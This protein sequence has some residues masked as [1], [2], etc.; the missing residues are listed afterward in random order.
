MAGGKGRSG[1]LTS[2]EHSKSPH[3][4]KKDL[5]FNYHWPTKF[6]IHKLGNK[7]HYYWDKTEN[8]LE[9]LDIKAQRM[10]YDPRGILGCENFERTV[11]KISE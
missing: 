4:T 5:I 6:R 7:G 2:L 3:H 10:Q 11:E 8:T 9:R 1:I